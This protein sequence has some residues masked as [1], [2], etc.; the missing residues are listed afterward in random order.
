MVDE[1]QPLPQRPP[2]EMAS[3][4]ATVSS[5]D[6]SPVMIVSV[7]FYPGS[8]ETMWMCLPLAP[9]SLTFLKIL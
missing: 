5:V 7:S 2:D 1:S 3:L 8:L 4:I 6:P 9:K